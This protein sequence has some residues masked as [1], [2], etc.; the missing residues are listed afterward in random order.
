MAEKDLNRSFQKLKQLKRMK[1]EKYSPANVYL[2]ILGSGAPGAPHCLYVSS[3][4]RTYMFNCGEGTQRLA[5]EHHLKLS[6]LNHIFFTTP[7]WKNIGGLPGLSLTI[8]DSGVPDLNLHGPK[9]IFGIY[10]AVKRFVMLTDLNVTEVS[11][12][13]SDTFQ[14]TCMSVRYVHLEKSNPEEDSDSDKLL[15]LDSYDD[16]DTDYYAHEFNKNGKRNSKLQNRNQPNYKV[17][18]QNKKLFK[19]VTGCISYI[20]KLTEVSG[21]LDFAKCVDFGIPP[22]PL[23]GQLKSGQDVTLDNGTVVKSSDV[24]HP[25]SSGPTFIVLE[26]P[27]E[28]YLDSLVDNK[29]FN[30]YQNNADKN[31]IPQYIVHF[32]PENVLRNSRYVDWM[33]KFSSETQHIIINETNNCL[34]HEAI[35][36]IQH[37]LHLLH[38]EIFPMLH[39]KDDSKLE[40]P[41]G[42]INEQFKA[43]KIYR[44]KTCN[45]FHL[46]PLDGF[47]NIEINLNREADVKEVLNVDGFLD[48]LA[49]LQTEINARS[50]YL[51][52]M[53]KYP[54]IVMLGTGSCI[55]NK[56]RNTS[57]I[58]L[59]IDE[60]TSILMDCGEDTFGQ[61]A[62]FFGKDCEKILKSIKAIYISHLHADHHLGLLGIIQKRKVVTDEPIFLLAPKQIESWIRL[63]HKKFERFEDTIIFVPN[64]G[65]LLNLERPSLEA[66]EELNRKLK[67]KCINT[68]GVL[69]CLHSFGI[70]LTLEN[71][72]KIVYSGDT[73]PCLGLVTLGENC[74]L[75]IHE[76][77]MEDGLEWE[78]TKKMHSTISQAISIGEQMNAKFTLLTHFSQRYS[79]MPRLPENSEQFNANNIGIAFDNMQFSLSQL[80]LLPLFYP[81]LRLMFSEFC[82]LLELKAHRRKLKEDEK[83]ATEEMKAN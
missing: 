4:H 45:V 16:D 5:H 24:C 76:A 41:F 40:T 39:E 75:L 71:G 54:K 11:C 49:E 59:R 66:I 22:G 67:L 78:A 12:E 19:R 1:N 69:H 72:K 70:A 18:K 38:P 34:N 68:V 25:A 23:L 6:K 20:C 35:H 29:V 65:L 82:N 81:A 53:P 80:S 28:D 83:R 51:N 47:D 57:G 52:D 77:T 13:E 7:T 61:I 36:R 74:D 33:C 31:N 17:P 2:Q 63:Y 10:D 55:P 14:D 26:C 3:D 46:R 48:V 64:Q 73:K 30:E 43:L 56:I 60:D 50:R 58:L 44:A 8:Q 42:E 15:D 37:K 79:K 27:D 21:K 32:T 62:R 9:G